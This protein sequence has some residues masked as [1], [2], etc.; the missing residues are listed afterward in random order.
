MKI[1]AKQATDKMGGDVEDTRGFLRFLEGHKI[2]T[3]LEETAPA[4]KGKGRGQNIYEVDES[5]LI[6]RL[7][8]LVRKVLP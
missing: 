1:T 6:D 8:Q 7:T 2:A 3:K 4:A 5:T